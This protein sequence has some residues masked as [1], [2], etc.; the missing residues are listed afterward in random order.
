VIIPADRFLMID[1]IVETERIELH[2]I[3]DDPDLWPEEVLHPCA[4]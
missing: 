2:E 4:T 1:N 3:Y